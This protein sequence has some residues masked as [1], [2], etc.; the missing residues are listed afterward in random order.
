METTTLDTAAN[1]AESSAP[2]DEMFAQIGMLRK[3]TPDLHELV[4]T[5]R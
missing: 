1:A 5:Q 4:E 2:G 3:T